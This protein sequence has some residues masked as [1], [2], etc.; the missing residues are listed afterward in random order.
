MDIYRKDAAVT[1]AMALALMRQALDLLDA[2]SE[3]TAGCH[4][5]AA[6][7][8]LLKKLPPEAADGPAAH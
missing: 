6:I 8:A 7:D 3:Q 1:K 4:L 5:Q 2:V